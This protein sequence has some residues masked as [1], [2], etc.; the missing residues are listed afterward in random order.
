MSSDIVK[1]LREYAEAEASGRY[2][3]ICSRDP[4]NL[5]F[6]TAA[7][8]IEALEGEAK[9]L[10]ASLRSAQLETMRNF[11]RAERLRVVLEGAVA[12]MNG[13]AVSGGYPAWHAKAIK[14]IEDDKQ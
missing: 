5:I 14:V 11:A 9:T 12:W 3:W 7:D 13:C 6:W 10:A 4:K 8:R 1:R 2:G